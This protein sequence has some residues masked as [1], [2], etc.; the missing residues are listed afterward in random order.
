MK[1]PHTKDW[2]LSVVCCGE[3]VCVAAH[4]PWSYDSSKLEIVSIFLWFRIQPLDKFSATMFS[5]PAKLEA[6]V[7]K[8]MVKHYRMS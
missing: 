4:K 3:E 8:L 1:I 7:Y 6:L 5:L 2:E